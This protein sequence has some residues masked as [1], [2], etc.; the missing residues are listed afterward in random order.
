MADG[1]ENIIKYK[2]F[3]YYE[4]YSNALCSADIHIHLHIFDPVKYQRGL[5]HT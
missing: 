5:H 3:C 4:F 2:N 1:S